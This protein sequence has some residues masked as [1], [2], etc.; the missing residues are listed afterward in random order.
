MTI[1]EMMKVR[2]RQLTMNET[3]NK[4]IVGACMPETR[5]LLQYSRGLNYQGSQQDFFDLNQDT[6]QQEIFFS[7]TASNPRSEARTNK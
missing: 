1:D 7:S 2:Q 4:R 3:M 6:N 5:G